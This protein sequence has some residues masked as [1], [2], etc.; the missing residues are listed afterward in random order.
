MNLV[1]RAKAILLRP[2][3]E[4][5]VIEG[6]THTVQE[7]YTQYVMILAAIP[8][9]AAFIGMSIVGVGGFGVSYR[10]PLANG[11]G[12]MVLSYLLDLAMVYVLAL[13]IDALAPTFNGQKDFPQAL[14]VAAF[15]PTAAWVA[16]VFGI[17]PVLGILALVGALYSLYL[18]YVGLPLLMN[19]SEDKALTYTVVVIAVAIVL[20]VVVGIMVGLVIPSPMRGF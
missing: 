10:V 8:A 16:G 13:I 11:L 4:W 2:K 14:K 17:I 15:A 7:L 19:A 9:V 3:D 6:E 1:E 18:L 20:R 12:V 5:P